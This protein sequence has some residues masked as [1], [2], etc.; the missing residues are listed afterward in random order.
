MKYE[1]PAMIE[2]GCGAI[3]NSSSVVGLL[4]QP[5][6]ASY[7]A[8]KH[9]VVG[10]TRSAALECASSS[11]RVNAVC[12][13]IVDTPML[14]RYT[15]GDAKLAAELTAQYPTPRVT[16]PAEVASA[17]LWLCSQDASYVNGHSLTIDGGLSVQ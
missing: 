16:Q 8:S 14:R 6:M 10:L 12:P 1:I 13:A 4:G 9:G 17:V 2:Q 11:I 7:V 15:G 5:N 3:V